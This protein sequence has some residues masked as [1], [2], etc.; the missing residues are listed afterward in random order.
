MFCILILLK[1]EGCEDVSPYIQVHT[2]ITFDKR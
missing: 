1:S 2:V